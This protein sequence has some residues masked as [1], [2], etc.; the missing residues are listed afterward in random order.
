MDAIRSL[1]LQRLINTAFHREVF[2]RICLHIEAETH[3]NS[4]V[5]PA[6]T[7]DFNNKP[8]LSG[9]HHSAA[10]P[11]KREAEKKETM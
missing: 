11:E 5:S 4:K 6:D 1:F 3:V 2:L 9:W 7:E 8:E 10:K